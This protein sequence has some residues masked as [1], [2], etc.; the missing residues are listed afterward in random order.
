MYLLYVNSIQGLGIY[1]LYRKQK[2]QL[3]MCV[4]V[5]GVLPRWL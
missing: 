4:C 3:C 2:V 5:G 1:L